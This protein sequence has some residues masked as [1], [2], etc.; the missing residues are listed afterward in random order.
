MMS[1]AGATYRPAI[2]NGWRV[3]RW[4]LATVVVLTPALMT[5]ISDGWHWT[6]GSFVVAAAAIAGFVGLYELAEH[7]NASRTYRTGIAVSLV[8][9]FLTL[10]TTVVRDDGSGMSFI[11]PVISAFLGAFV[12]WLRPAGLART[13]FGVAIMQAL[14]GMAVAT[15]PVT[16][17]V[18]DGPRKALVAAGAFTLLW[19]AAAVLFSVAAR[20]RNLS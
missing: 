2:W 10:W 16:A 18:P 6:L 19:L 9:S 8:T 17:N 4:S 1:E 12:A 13:A 7:A 20:K 14:S 15:A 5:R 11:L 3:V